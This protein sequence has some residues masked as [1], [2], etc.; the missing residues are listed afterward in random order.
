MTKI[1]NANITQFS[2]NRQFLAIKRISENTIK[3]WSLEYRKKT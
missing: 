2:S 1:I 3:L